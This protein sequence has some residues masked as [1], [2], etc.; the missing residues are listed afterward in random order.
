MSLFD[1]IKK[2]VTDALKGEGGAAATEVHPGVFDGVVAM[3]R[4]RGLSSLI[5]SLEKGGLADAVKSWIGH[6]E[7]VPVTGDQIKAALGSDALENLAK[8]AGISIQDVTAAL[9]KILP[10]LVD[11]L[12]PTGVVVDKPEVLGAEPSTGTTTSF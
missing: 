10:G 11:K 2:Q 5:E 7:N 9:A 12:T 6:G 1:A 3:I 8:Q 4:D